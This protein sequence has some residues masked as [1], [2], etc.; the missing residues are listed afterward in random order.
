MMSGGSVLVTDMAEKKTCLSSL[1]SLKQLV[2]FEI[3]SSIFKIIFVYCNHIQNKNLR[4]FVDWLLTLIQR[5]NDCVFFFDI[6]FCTLY[7][8]REEEGPEVIIGN[9]R[10]ELC[11][12][13]R[14]LA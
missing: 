5:E 6:K 2:F 9:R 7:K 10:L 4:F 8:K 13:W 3:Q 1:K 11:T 12:D 14:I